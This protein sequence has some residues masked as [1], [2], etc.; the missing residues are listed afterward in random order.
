MKTCNTDSEYKYRDTP[1]GRFEVVKEWR[2]DNY[3]QEDH[4]VYSGS[5]SSVIDLVDVLNAGL[6]AMNKESRYSFLIEM[7]IAQIKEYS[8]N[9]YIGPEGNDF[10]MTIKEIEEEVGLCKKKYMVTY[11]VE[12][13]M[14]VEAM[15]AKEAMGMVNG[16]VIKVEEID[17]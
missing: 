5:E 1:D 4:I 14:E 8:E 3:D 10:A 15:C 12:A 9:E 17:T 6:T 13:H 2:E 11:N 16:T 7:L